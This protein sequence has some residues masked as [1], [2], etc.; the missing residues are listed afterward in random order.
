MIFR[1]LALTILLIT[2]ACASGTADVSPNL[3]TNPGFESG[4]TGWAPLW[5]HQPNTGTDIVDMAVP[6]GGKASLRVNYTGTQDWSVGQSENLPVQPG[7][8]LTLSGWIKG[9]GAGDVEISVV[10]HGADGATIDWLAAEENVGGTHDWQQLT[11]RWVVPAGVATVQFRFTGW[12]PGTFWLDDSV[13]TREGNVG[14]AGVKLQAKTLHLTNAVLD[15][16]VN[17]GDGTLVV[18][19]R[20]GGGA[21]WRQQPLN[22]GLIV[23]TAHSLGPRSLELTVWDAVNDLTLGATLTVDPAKPEITVRLTGNGPLRQ[24]VAFPAAWTSGPG[25]WLILPM[26]EG[27]VYPGGRRRPSPPSRSTPTRAT[28]YACPGT[29]SPTRAPARACRRSCKRPTTPTWTL[30]GSSAA[31]CTPS[32]PG[33]P[34]AARSL[35]TRPHLCLFGQR[36]LR[37]AGQ[38]L[39][40]L[41]AGDGPVQDAGAEAAA[42]PN[43]DLL[44]GAVNVWNWDPDKVALC[45]EMKSLGM[46]HVLWSG[47]G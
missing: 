40:R 15:V 31:C 44:V 35:P 29:A 10:T 9:E 36:R 24:S 16:R 1:L 42:N 12:G 47:G 46:D 21:V 34:R 17:E 45:R 25:T 5:T 19:D 2:T 41:R 22:P 38:A 32:P 33:K 39:P 23:K 26:N 8:I 4:M 3:L 20:R 13:L 27:I 7:D 11:R 30:P 28:A 18:T 6:H 43:V 37:R 14:P